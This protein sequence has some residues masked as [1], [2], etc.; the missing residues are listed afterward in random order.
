MPQTSYPFPMYSGL[1]E[2]EHYKNIGS[3]I[4]LFLWCVSST[5]SEKEKDGIVWG[6]VL[7]NKPVKTEEL[8]ASFDVSVRTIRDWLKVLREHE[9]IRVTRA[10]T[11]IILTVRKSKKFLHRSAEKFRSD[12][13]DSAD[14]LAETGG[15]RQ[16]SSDHSE[17]RS[18]ESCRSNKDIIGFKDLA[19][20]VEEDDSSKSDD[21]GML[22]PRHG[23]DP[24]AAADPDADSGQSGVSFTDFRQVI[25]DKFISR[26]ARGT[27][28]SPKDEDALDELATCNV[29]L[30]TVLRGIDKAY[31][32]YKPKHHRDA[33][34][35]LDYCVPI[36]LD[37]YVAEQRKRET[38][39]TKKQRKSKQQ[40]ELE[41]L[42]RKR[43]EARQR[44]QR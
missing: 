36:I 9:Y 24:A 11:G 44:D 19:V 10:P 30:D 22:L 15:D 33:V 28:L 41:D 32:E 7:G 26:R 42:R 34:R 29:P 31:D 40:Q 27:F 18:A 1:L 6:I 13:Q 37:L 2:P 20:V 14:H 43:E 8:A 3:A 35:T 17:E 16:N 5:T 25:I 4:W 21:E 23:A 38:P 39:G 12:R